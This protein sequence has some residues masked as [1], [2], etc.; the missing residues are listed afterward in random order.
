MKNCQP[1]SEFWHRTKSSTES[2]MPKSTT[3]SS[4]K[5]RPLPH[6]VIRVFSNSLKLDRMVR[7]MEEHTYHDSYA[8]DDEP[9]QISP[10]NHVCRVNCGENHREHVSFSEQNKQS[11][12]KIHEPEIQTDFEQGDLQR[13][14]RHDE[15]NGSY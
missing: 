9:G 2:T 5:K 15:A 6:I 8:G 13:K 4:N 10:V 14:N 7:Q 12:P 1:G 3:G 11:D